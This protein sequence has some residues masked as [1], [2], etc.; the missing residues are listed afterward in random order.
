[1]RIYFA[2]GGKTAEYVA[3][4][5]MREEHTLVV[6]DW[7]A[8]RTQEL[9]E[10]LD[11]TIICGDVASIRDAKSAGLEQADIFVACTD[12][13]ETNV[14][15]CLIADDLAPDAVKAIVLGTEEYRDWD[16]M[17]RNLKVRVDR[18][19]H[20]ESDIVERILRVITV[21]GVAD[22]R[23]FCEA[24]VKVFALHVDGNSPLEGIA[25]TALAAES[26]ID[27]QVCAIFR[28][29][30]ALVSSPDLRIRAGDNVYIIT[31]VAAL[32]S[33]FKYVG[34]SQRAET[35]KVFVVGG[36]EIAFE[37]A[38]RLEQQKVVV[39]LFDTDPD[40]CEL[41]SE[42]LQDTL[43]LHADGTDQDTLLKEGIQDVDVF[44]SLTSNDSHNIVA[45][46]LARRL[47]VNKVIPLVNKISNQHL[48][49]KLGISTT[50][51]PRVKTA[52][53]LLEYIRGGGVLSVRTLGEE[54]VEAIEIK[55]EEN[56]LCCNTTIGKLPLPEGAIVGAVVSSQ[57][58]TVVPDSDQVLR[59]GDRVVFF[60]NEKAIQ[61]FENKILGRSRRA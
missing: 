31:S 35:K 51:S 13:D 44:I 23:D 29:S 54:E 26:G 39:K 41:L 20:P 30:E 15:A 12:S 42:Q 19:V 10:N 9:A 1:M 52:D 60:V 4:R 49:Q 18:I 56:S 55:V 24:Q 11:A 48:A 47:G 22:I 28:G 43:I 21:P 25:S 34:V 5:L 40:R 57:S 33:A 6:M 45:S 61:K 3:H 2:G 36:G 27:M 58:Q 32:K 17:L 14:L 46:L 38:R 37:L 7:N 59:L 16:R 8:A 53:A 50:V